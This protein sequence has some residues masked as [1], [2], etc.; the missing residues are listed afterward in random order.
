MITS[1]YCRKSAISV[2]AALLLIL[3]ACSSSEEKASYSLNNFNLRS[4]QAGDVLNYSTQGS[5]TTTRNGIIDVSGEMSTRY[6]DSAVSTPPGNLVSQFNTL[7]TEDTSVVLSGNNVANLTRDFYQ[8]A[9]GNLY[10]ASLVWPDGNRLWLSPQTGTD[11]A[12]NQVDVSVQWL[13][14]PIDST[15]TQ[16]RTFDLHLCDTNLNSCELIGNGQER[17]T[18]VGFDNQETPYAHF[19]SIAIDYALSFNITKQVSGF[20]ADKC[21]SSGTR[22]I[23]PALGVVKFT[24]SYQCQN[25]TLDLIVA[26]NSTTIKLN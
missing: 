24:L 13:A 5:R 26:I 8:D 10:V 4:Y 3:T 7:L 19:E 6:T 9:A 14:S 18:Y 17:Q 21:E 20:T 15:T 25:E 11:S 23:Y 1:D 12:T 16:T 2:Y 22:W